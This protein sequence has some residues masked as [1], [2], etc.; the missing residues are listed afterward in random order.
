MNDQC[1][2]RS[3]TNDVLLEIFT[4]E[5]VGT[6]VLP[7]VSTR[8]RPA[9]H[10]ATTTSPV[11]GERLP[12][13]SSAQESATLNGLGPGGL[14]HRHAASLMNTYGPPRRVLTRGVGCHVWDDGGRRY[15][16]LLAGI[17]VNALGHA[18]PDVVATV[19]RQAATLSHVSNFFA[20]EPQVLLAERLLALTG[21]GDGR[22][23]FTS[24]GT[25][26]TE[27]AVK[28]TRRTG[29]TKIVAAEGGFHGRTMGALALTSKA[30][31]RTP[32]L[33]LAGH[34]EFVPY[35]D[36]AALEAAVDSD[37]A[38]LVLEPIQGE[39][40]VVEPP[41]GYLVG[42]RR[43]ADQHG[44]LLWFDEVQTGIGRTG[45]WFGYQHEPVL[46]D[47]VTVAKA[48]GG[49]FPIGACLGLG[50]TGM[51]FEP[52]QHGTTFGG[53]PLAASVALTVLDVIERDDLLANTVHQGSRLREA[54][55]TLPGLEH[56]RGRGLHVAADVLPG[57]AQ[58]VARAALEAELIVNDVR[59]DA[60]RFVPPLVLESQHIEEMTSRLGP[61][62]ASIS[63][64]ANLSEEAS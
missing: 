62:L 6:Q 53:N 54:L 56:V 33:P 39:A 3:T 1:N 13:R 57:R 21:A 34:V 64:T 14:T 37:T 44:A 50:E 47:L 46:P 27:A 48:L 63:A 32:F 42:A 2:R 15:L 30:A 59:P 26:A 18:H 11:H 29:R 51:F 61:V 17:A 16:D 36:L 5:G 41:S 31:Y 19:S 38:A 43:V 60:L 25:E 20:T 24:S 45:H 58:A 55:R 23:F 9:K 28:L 4:D 49:G 40:G 10:A 35:G 22:V 52:G 8:L 7:G 12:R